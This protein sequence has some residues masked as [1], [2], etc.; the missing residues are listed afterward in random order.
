MFKVEFI[1]LSA[2]ATVVLLC[3]STRNLAEHNLRLNG[4]RVIDIVDL[5]R[6][7]FAE[8]H[9]LGNRR[10]IL[11]F[12]VRRD[13]DLGGGEFPDPEAA[14]AFALDQGDLF[15]E[16]GLLR[17]TLVGTKTSVTRWLDNAFV[18]AHDLSEV[19]GIAN[20]YSYTINAGRISTSRP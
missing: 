17:I 20:R 5:V 15:D 6:A 10:N 16:E 8:G 1:T 4:R 13:V 9:Y 14:F 18:E 2:P 12:E 19:L 3:N 7:D 11:S